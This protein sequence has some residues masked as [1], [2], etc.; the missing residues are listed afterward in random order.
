MCGHLNIL[1]GYTD[2]LEKSTVATVNNVDTLLPSEPQYGKGKGKDKGFSIMISF[3]RNHLICYLFQSW[4]G[5]LS[6]IILLLDFISIQI[7]LIS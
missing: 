6:V 2:R 4:F 3:L 7:E 1:E 5:Y